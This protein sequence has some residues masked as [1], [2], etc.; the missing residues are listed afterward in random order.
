MLW[1]GDE[2]DKTILVTLT[3]HA[4]PFR[5]SEDASARLTS[6]L[7]Q[8]TTRLSADPDRTDIVADL[9]RSSGDRLSALPGSHD[10]RVSLAEMDRILED[11]GSVETGH[12][13]ST[14]ELPLQPR[15]RRLRRIREGQQVAGVCTGLADYAQLDV[16]W[17]RTLFL[18]GTVATVGVGAL[19]YFALA[20]VLPISAT[21][22]SPV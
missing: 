18:A 2:M 4:E 8:A 22:E 19:V 17:V 13:E 3:G 12:D 7:E 15:V 1:V 20:F 6:Y 10:G 16:A 5:L 21:R 11:V 14:N 9:E